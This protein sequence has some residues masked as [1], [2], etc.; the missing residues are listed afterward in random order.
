[1]TNLAWETFDTLNLISVS[2]DCTIIIWEHEENSWTVKNRL[3]QLYG[4]KNAFFGIA[5]ND[6]DK[7]IVA[8]NFT[9]A[10][11]VWEYK[12]DTK[13]FLSKASF[14]GHFDEVKGIE[15]SR[16]GSF[17]VSTSKDQTT[18]VIAKN[19]K[20]STYHEISRAQIHGY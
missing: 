2:W 1:M 18:R 8:V 17:L 4:N 20:T 13:T 3:G 7:S 19:H 12:P 15:W 16:D 5:V 11:C 6:S 14:N 9:G 10:C